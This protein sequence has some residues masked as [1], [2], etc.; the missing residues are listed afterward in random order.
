[1]LGKGRH[2]CWV[3]GDTIAG[4]GDVVWFGRKSQGVKEGLDKEW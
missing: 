4:S 3:R 1:M 2:H